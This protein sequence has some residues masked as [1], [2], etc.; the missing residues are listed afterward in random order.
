M[1][2]TAVRYGA[3]P[4]VPSREEARPEGEKHALLRENCRYFLLLSLGLGGLFAVCFTET[5]GLGLN[6]A[7]W[8]AGWCVWAHLSLKKLGAARLRR[9]GVWYAAAALLGLSVLWTANSFIQFVSMVGCCLVQ[10]LWALNVFADIRD[11]HFGKAAGA[12]LRL[13]F[14]SMR[15]IF[16]PFRHAVGLKKTEGSARYVLLGLLIALPLAALVTSLLSGADAVFRGLVRRVFSPELPDFLRF[17]FKAL[18]FAVGAGAAFYA[19]LCAQTDAPEAE[20]QPEVGKAPAAVAVTFTAVLAGIYLLFC[21]I[22]IGVLFARSGALLPA[23]CTYARYAREGF[24]QLLLVSGINV[25]LVIV[26]QRRFGSGPALKT[27]LF[28]ISGCTYVMEVSS[29]WRLALYVSVY[30]LTFWRLLALWFLAV[31]GIVLAGAVRT[32]FRP[33][34]RLFR[35]SLAVCLTAWLVF[36]FA[37]PDTLAARYDLQRF[38]PTESTVSAIRSDLAPDALEE[39]TPY[40]S[41]DNRTVRD[42]MDGW[43]DRGIPQWYHEAGLRGFNYSLWRAAETGVKYK[44]VYYHGY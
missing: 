37:R 19:L 32:V 12:V 39:L 21:A 43:L 22:Q 34:F 14:R 15:R 35:F 25:L 1:N 38:G 30:G 8:A 24:F 6:F 11:W 44:E 20:G 23:G 17:G 3:V 36:A 9:D 29:V 10:C 27:L 7:L 13:A 31:L 4:T 2:E 26:S 40:L 18:L 33:D 16:E 42:H 28:V 5:K 41:R